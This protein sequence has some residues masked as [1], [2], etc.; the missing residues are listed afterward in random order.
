MSAYVD[1]APTRQ[2]LQAL[3]V[4]GFHAAWIA[5]QVGMNRTTACDIRAGRNP[6]IQAYAAHSINRLYQRLNGATP[7]TA[8]LTADRHGTAAVARTQLHAARN[9]WTT[10]PAAA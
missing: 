8:G 7:D 4:R 10:M 5:S 6:R 1:A 3:A 2:Q 9:H